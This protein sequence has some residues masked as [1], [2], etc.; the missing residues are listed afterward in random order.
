MWEGRK[1][2]IPIAKDWVGG[3]YCR[4]GL[5]V[6][7]ELDK[8]PL[9]MGEELNV[10]NKPKFLKVFIQLVDS[11]V[12]VRNFVNLNAIKQEKVRKHRKAHR[13]GNTRTE[14]EQLELCWCF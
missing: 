10:D 6:A 3:F 9:F 1:E 8:G 4:L 5:C 14:P 13:K 12:L 2:T 11:Q 7:A